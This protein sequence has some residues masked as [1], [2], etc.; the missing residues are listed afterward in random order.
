MKKRYLF[1]A[2]ALPTSALLFFDSFLLAKGLYEQKPSDISIGIGINSNIKTV[3]FASNSVWSSSNDLNI[4]LWDSTSVN[5][6]PTAWPGAAMTTV[7]TTTNH[8]IFSYEVDTSKYDKMIFSRQLSG[9]RAQTN[10]I[11]VSTIS[12]TDNCYTLTATSYTSGTNYNSTISKYDSSAVSLTK[13][14]YFQVSQSWW[15]ADDSYSGLY[16]FMG[17][18][19]NSWPGTVM[20]RVNSSVNLYQGLINVELYDTI[21]VSRVSSAG[22]DWGAKTEDKTLSLFDGKQNSLILTQSSVA[23]GG[24]TSTAKV[25]TYPET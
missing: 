2:L 23:W 19:D 5:A 16:Q 3:Y 20:S 24:A 1:L 9:S 10:N 22:A 11:D 7:T 12:G 17:S 18:T 13:D 8:S 21:V 6:V 14:F 4:Y 15:M 25:T